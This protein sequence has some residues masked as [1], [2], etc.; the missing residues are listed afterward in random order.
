MH[1]K[2][3]YNICRSEISLLLTAKFGIKRQMVLLISNITSI[4]K[5]KKLQTIYDD[6]IIVPERLHAEIE[7]NLVCGTHFAG[8][9]PLDITSKLERTRYR[10]CNDDVI[11]LPAVI[12]ICI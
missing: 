4:L 6:A 7:L 8:D 2:R 11:T 9:L 3:I 12:K 5:T 10:P 1:Q